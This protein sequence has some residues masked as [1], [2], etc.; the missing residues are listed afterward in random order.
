MNNSTFQLIVLEDARTFLK[1]L[2]PQVRKKIAF[3]IDKVKAGIKDNEL[4]K[5]LKYGSSALYIKVLHT[6]YL[7]FGIQM[8][9]PW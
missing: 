8:N 7:H 5:I 6:D 9:K 4:F 3:N 1:S 2:H